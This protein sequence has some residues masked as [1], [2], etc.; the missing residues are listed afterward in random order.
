MRSLVES[1]N[2]C[3]R[4]FFSIQNWWPRIFHDFRVLWWRRHPEPSARN[5][6]LRFQNSHQWYTMIHHAKKE[7]NILLDKKHHVGSLKI[8]LL[9]SKAEE[10]PHHCEHPKSNL[11][12][13]PSPATRTKDQNICMTRQSAC[14]KPCKKSWDLKNWDHPAKMPPPPQKIIPYSGII[15]GSLWF[16]NLN[17]INHIRPVRFPLKQRILVLD[18][19]FQKKYRDRSWGWTK[20][21]LWHD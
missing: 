12:P 18:V 14:P 19:C 6:C 21:W 2:I 16:I 17:N 11:K 5:K 15:K 4:W 13:G 9:K 1:F 3:K 20:T 8:H 7:V 10:L